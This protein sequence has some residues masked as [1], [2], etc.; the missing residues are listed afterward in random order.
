MN[1]FCIVRSLIAFRLLGSNKDYLVV[2]T[3]SGKVTVM[4]FIVAY[5]QSSWKTLHC[6]TFG[7]T[8]CR[9]IVPGQYLAADP[10]GRAI[11]VSAIE[12]QH[13]V[14][15]MN[16]DGNNKLTISSPLEA[17]KGGI[18]LYSCVGLD[19]GLEN[20]MFALLELDYSDVDADPTGDAAKDA[21]KLLTFYELDLGLNHVVRKW[22]EPVSRLANFLLAVPGG[23]LG[24]GGVLVCGEN[25]I[26]YK[27]QDH[28]EVRT[29]LP[30]RID[31][32]AT[33]G[34]LPISGALH[35]QK[36]MYFFLVQTEYGD[37]YKVTLDVSDAQGQKIVSNVYVSVFDT[38]QP[39]NSLCITR[40]G[41]LF[42]SSE[43]CNHTLYQFASLGDDED[44]VRAE[45]CRDENVGDDAEETSA[46]A[47]LFKPSVKLRTF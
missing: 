19:V 12:K 28:P 44:T 31:M 40:S 2:G 16:R 17:H 1:C 10:H 29:A 34:L 36:G 38:V 7:K 3:D 26:S 13:F 14:Y 43:H 39:A 22:C 46:V 45:K 6:E 15:V 27:N 8:G 21:E 18:V 11:M 37:I 24:P 25:W 32:P 30:R 47:L 35:K 23:D 41:L 4:E 33:R 20:P 42:V 5:G 9:R